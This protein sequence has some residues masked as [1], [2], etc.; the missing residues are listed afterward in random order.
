M[1]PSV[2]LLWD[3]VIFLFSQQSLT[4]VLKVMCETVYICI[5]GDTSFSDGTLF[6]L[7]FH[8]TCTRSKTFSEEIEERRR[9]IPSTQVSLF[10]GRTLSRARPFHG[11]TLSRA[12]LFHGRW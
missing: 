12:R 1:I 5:Y 9:D 11:R 8:Y 6:S 7:L 2:V 3:Y 10:H 4:L